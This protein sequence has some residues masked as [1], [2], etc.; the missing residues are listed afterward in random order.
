[1]KYTDLTRKDL[2]SELISLKKSNDDLKECCKKAGTRLSHSEELF[3]KAFTTNPDSVNINRME[4][5]MFVT[6]NDGFTRITGYTWEDVKN[7][8]SLDLN[9]WQNTSDRESIVEELKTKGNVDNFETVFIAKNGDFINGLMS[10]SIIDLDGIP[11]ILNITKD[12]TERKKIEAELRK[13]QF[14]FNALMDNLKDAVYFKDLES[15]FIRINRMHIDKFGISDPAEA[16]GKTD[17][18][19][20]TGEHAGSSLTDEQEIIST[21]KAITKEERETQEGKTDRW[22]S[23]VKMPM[24]DPEGKIVGTFGISRDITERKN[25]EEQI[26]ILANALKSVNECV[27]ITD[28]NDNVVF[29]NDAFLR[30][31]GFSVEDLKDQPIACIRS[32]KNPPEVVG[33]ILPDTIMG[34]WSGEILNCRKDGSEFPISLSTSIVKDDSGKPIALIGVANDIT[35]RKRSEMEKEVIN[36]IIRGVTTTSD[37]DEFLRRVHYSLSGIVSA[38]NIVIALYNF[39]TNQFTFPYFID[40]YDEIPP[41]SVMKK[42]CTS[43]IFR[44]GKALVFTKEVLEK[45]IMENEVEEIGSPS[46]S[47]V[48]IPLKTPSRIIGVLVLQDYETENAYTERDVDFLISVGSQIAV[49]IER[50]QAEGAIKLKNS[51]LTISNAEKDKFFSI[52]AHDL[53]GPLGSFVEATKLITEHSQLMTMEE[54]VEL[55]QTMKKEASSIFGLLENLLDWSRLKRGVLGFDPVKINIMGEVISIVE[56]LSEISLRKNIAV[57]NCITEDYETEADKNMFDTIVRNLL[58]NAIKFTPGGGRIVI[59]AKYTKDNMIEISVCDSGIGMDDD[60]KGK[61]FML[62]E[63]T[64]RPG[65]EGEPSSGL[66]LH[67]CKEFVEKHGGEMHV[68]SEPGRGSCFSFTLKKA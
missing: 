32:P 61:L 39:E 47:W 17:F 27:S 3:R 51:Q 56:L 52:I 57:E 34:G 58:S 37:L 23:T 36:D 42:S 68:K 13:E 16:I 38:E 30:T 1:M 12:I 49:A 24:I 8:T 60:L 54:V 19:F 66:G 20:F 65:T 10:A 26:L 64:S 63:R 18:D 28:M 9:M 41:P 40:K 45:L 15:R 48:G 67:L 59:S 29:L 31:Y 2:I 4:D 6:I 11:H 50:W 46:P 21:G 5:G 53:R 25:F 33:K 14:L 43:Y 55:T 44:S 7:R 35:D 22:V 62:S